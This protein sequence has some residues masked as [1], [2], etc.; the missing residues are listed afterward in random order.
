NRL[1]EAIT[2]WACGDKRE[3]PAG[4]VAADEPTAGRPRGAAGGRAVNSCFTMSTIQRTDTAASTTLMR[5][6]R[7]GIQLLA[8]PCALGR[9]NPEIVS[10]T[11]SSLGWLRLTTRTLRSWTGRSLVAP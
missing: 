6:S 4:A 9:M 5:R 8:L 11:R 3:S 2:L 1:R 7:R 10:V